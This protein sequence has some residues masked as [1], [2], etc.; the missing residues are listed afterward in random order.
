MSIEPLDACVD[1][2]KVQVPVSECDNG[3]VQRAR[4]IDSTEVKTADRGLRLQPIVIR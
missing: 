4:A 1:S 3:G 2:N